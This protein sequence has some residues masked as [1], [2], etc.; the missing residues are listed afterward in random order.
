MLWLIDR[1]DPSEH[2]PYVIP[3]SVDSVVVELMRPGI[4]SI[5]IPSDGIV[6]LWITLRIGGVGNPSSVYR[7]FIDMLAIDRSTPS[8][9]IV[10]RNSSHLWSNIKEFLESTYRRG[11]PFSP[12]KCCG[13][14]VR[15]A[16]MN[17]RSREAFESLT[18]VSPP[19]VNS[20]RNPS[21][22]SMAGVILMCVPYSV[23]NHLKIF[24][25]VGIPMI[26]VAAVKMGSPP[27]EV[28][29]KVV[30]KLRSVKSMVIPPAKTAPM[31]MSIDELN[32]I[33][34]GGSSQ[35]PRLFS[36]GKDISVAPTIIGISQFPN[37]LSSIGI[38]IKK[39]MYSEISPFTLNV[40]GEDRIIRIRA[41]REIPSIPPTT[42][43]KMYSVP[44]FLWFPDSR[45]VVNASE[46]NSTW[47]PWRPVVIKKILPFT[48]LDIVNVDV[49]YSTYCTVINIILS[50]SVSSS[51]FSGL[52]SGTPKGLGMFS[53][54][55]GHVPCSGISADLKNIQKNIQCRIDSPR[56]GIADMNDVITV[57]AQKLM[58]PHG[59]TYPMKATRIVKNRIRLPVSHLPGNQPERL[60]AANYLVIY[61]LMFSF[62]LLV[63]VIRFLADCSVV[64]W[65]SV[66][67][68]DRA[69]VEA[70]V[71]GRM[72][73]ASILLKTGGY[74]LVKVSG[75]SNDLK[76][77]VAYS[78][79]THMTIVLGLVVMGFEVLD[80]AVVCLMLSHGVLSNSMFFMV[81]V[82]STSNGSF[83][84]EGRR[85]VG[86]KD[87]GGN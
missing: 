72:I 75:L 32:S 52:P 56:I 61:T 46:P 26:I 86:S 38:T 40:H 67:W 49:R 13:M 33:R 50:I 30:P 60:M 15:L 59:I 1:R 24:T 76:K 77:F 16:P 42:P 82:T 22:H 54:V 47:S 12:R 45:H 27:P 74:G 71:L 8:G 41:D 39:I 10:Q 5:L 57:A 70:P 31:L 44:I 79:V 19:I 65:A 68:V 87:L 21:T 83:S 9:E 20:K 34:A 73:L 28:S 80:S 2:C 66:V 48:P 3:G 85:V 78:S 58:F 62:P 6:H 51:Q 11:I 81:G 63:L 53:E 64:G 37:P 35:N 23:A 17:I 25:P 84:L 69:H 14:N 55:G 29:K 4:A 36:R 43:N 7:A 18:P